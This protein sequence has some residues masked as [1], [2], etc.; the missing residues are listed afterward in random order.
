MS[1][2]GRYD[3]PQ[4]DS[5]P[6]HKKVIIDRRGTDSAYDPRRPRDSHPD[7]R[8]KPSP[9]APNFKEAG[10][11]RSQTFA[12]I[13]KPEIPVPY[14]KNPQPYEGE[15]LR[16]YRYYKSLHDRYDETNHKYKV[17]DPVHKSR[18]YT[19]EQREEAHGQ[20]IAL[21][22]LAQRQAK[23]IA[24]ARTGFDHKYPCAQPSLADKERHNGEV[25]KAMQNAKKYNEYEK[26]I[27][28]KRTGWREKRLAGTL[29]KA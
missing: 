8:P 14:V 13:I 24:A 18:K 19:H 2:H 7:S 26:I 4:W 12:T 29:R 3:N 9:Y 16:D 28:A 10:Q 23:E 5:D 17:L 11:G 20:G 1:R 25:L 21:A 6:R 15:S 22:K 27:E